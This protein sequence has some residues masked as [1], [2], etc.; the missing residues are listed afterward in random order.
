MGEKEMGNEKWMYSHVG[1]YGLVLSYIGRLRRLSADFSTLLHRHRR[2]LATFSRP[3]KGE[4]SICLGGSN[5]I[6][7][8]VGDV[9]LVTRSLCYGRDWNGFL[10]CNK[11]SYGG[12]D[13]RNITC[14]DKI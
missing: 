4:N 2:G 14:I 13:G 3:E 1:K 8:L 9:W 7:Y 6:G 5:W 11:F 12:G 10:S